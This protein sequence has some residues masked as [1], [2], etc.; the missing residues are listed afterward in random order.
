MIRVQKICEVDYKVC[1]SENQSRQVAEGMILDQQG[2]RHEQG[3]HRKQGEYFDEQGQAEIFSH[4]DDIWAVHVHLEDL[5]EVGERG[6]PAA[7]QSEDDPR[8]SAEQQN[9]CGRD[10]QQSQILGGNQ[11]ETTFFRCAENGKGAVL[12]FVQQKS[13]DEDEDEQQHTDIAIGIGEI[14]IPALAILKADGEILIHGVHVDHVALVAVFVAVRAHAVGQVFLLKQLGVVDHTLQKRG[15]LLRDV[16]A[17]AVE[18]PIGIEIKIHLGSNFIIIFGPEVL[19]GVVA[20]LAP[21]HGL[22]VLLGHQR[23]YFD[24]CQIVRPTA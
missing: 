21:H 20:L 7:L 2:D 18:I 6:I 8:C 3:A 4:R 17:D 9:R 14:H 15:V 10:K 11:R 12:F 22:H 1:P 16:S 24:G 5:H 19:Y 13:R 23:G